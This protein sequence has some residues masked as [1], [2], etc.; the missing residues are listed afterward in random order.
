M[1]AVFK[2]D[3]PLCLGMNGV[4][5]RDTLALEATNGPL[6]GEGKLNVRALNSFPMNAQITLRFLDEGEQEISVL[7]EDGN[8]SAGIASGGAYL[9]NESNFSVN[10][11]SEVLASLN[12]ASKIILEVT[13][14]TEGE[15]LVKMYGE[16]K[17][18]L[19]ITAEGSI[20]LSYE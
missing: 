2:A 14:N 20:Q 17:I 3:M 6:V 13:M 4:F 15:D 9:A 16:E 12:A 19:L 7:L 1:E 18:D 10:I 11:T 5:F 8:V